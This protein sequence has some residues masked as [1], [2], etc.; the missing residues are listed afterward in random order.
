MKTMQIFHSIN[1][2]LFA[3][4]S[5]VIDK[6]KWL[7]Q[8][9]FVC[10]WKKREKVLAGFW[11]VFWIFLD[12]F[13]IGIGTIYFVEM[14]LCER[15]NCEVNGSVANEDAVQRI[16]DL[17]MIIVE[18]QERMKELEM[19]IGTLDRTRSEAATRSEVEMSSTE[20]EAEVGK[21]VQT[22]KKKVFMKGKDDE[23]WIKYLVSD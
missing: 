22:K 10:D 9:Y 17:Q 11:T 19:I 3:L 13:G 8:V 1:M 16:A 5:L 4:F 12:N 6:S 20:E 14:V 18:L 21:V 7:D 23:D 15:C 2:K